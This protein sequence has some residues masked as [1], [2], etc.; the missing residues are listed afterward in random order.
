[1]IDV[2]PLSKRLAWLLMGGT[3]LAGA[4]GGGMGAVLSL[5]G[6]EH[7]RLQTAEAEIQPFLAQK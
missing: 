7:R 2:R 6:I 3:L 1:V 4:D 5:H